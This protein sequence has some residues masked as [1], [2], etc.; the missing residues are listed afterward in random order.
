MMSGVYIE[1]KNLPDPIQEYVAWV[2]I[3]GTKNIFKQTDKT[4]TSYILKLHTYAKNAAKDKVKIANIYP[5]IDGFFITHNS[6]TELIEVIQYIF[7]G[8]SDD[9]SKC[10]DGYGFLVRAGIA[11]GN[12]I[13]GTMI[14][15]KIANLDEH[16]KKSLLF[17]KAVVEAASAEREAPPFSIYV[18]DESRQ[19]FIDENIIITDS[20]LIIWAK[21][22]DLNILQENVIKYFQHREMHPQWD[23]YPVEKMKQHK[24]KFLMM[25]EETKSYF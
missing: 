13:H 9:L 21:E 10:R 23:E 20:G 25:I 5:V 19:N 16:I 6:A 1:T 22:A 14:D 18:A 8:I 3:M 12:V 24:S 17:G 2:D 15:S 4:P 11:Y 7:K